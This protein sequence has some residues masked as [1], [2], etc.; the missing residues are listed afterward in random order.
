[1]RF[2]DEHGGILV[3]VA[4]FSDG[5]DVATEPG[6]VGVREGGSLVGKFDS[7]VQ[8]VII[9]KGKPRSGASAASDALQAPGDAQGKGPVP[10]NSSGVSNELRA[11][12]GKALS[13]P[14]G[15]YASL[16]GEESEAVKREPWARGDMKKAI[17]DIGFSN[18]SAENDNPGKGDG[19]L[20]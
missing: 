17:E 5:F 3:E 2:R 13:K 16:G 1:M 8:T 7:L 14:K 4:G 6:P 20:F 10:A 12:L 15:L 19:S 9:P 18:G 11:Y